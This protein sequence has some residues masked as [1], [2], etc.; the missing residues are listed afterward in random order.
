MIKIRQFISDINELYNSTD[1]DFS[2]IEK[3]QTAL[4]ALGKEKLRGHFLRSRAS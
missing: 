1:F 4:E 3:K 2:L